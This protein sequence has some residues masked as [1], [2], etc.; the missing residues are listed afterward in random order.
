MEI[1]LRKANAI[2]ASINEVIK[3]LDF[4]PNVEV[5]EFHNVN[6]LLVLEH[7]NFMQS[8][9]RRTDL[10]DSLYEIRDLVAKANATEIDSILTKIARLEKDISFF[11][12]LVKTSPREDMGVIEGKLNK[13]RNRPQP[14]D[15]YGYG[16]HRDE[17]VVSVLTESDI[18]GY[19]ASVANLKRQKQNLQDRLLELNVSTK[20]TL[21]QQTVQVLAAEHIL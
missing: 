7:T 20:I 21:S 16:H 8:V 6:D 19:K 10:L 5:N 13:I 4:K 15:P 11:F 3:S 18:S 1:T 9:T 17:I 14:S 2:Q 12:D